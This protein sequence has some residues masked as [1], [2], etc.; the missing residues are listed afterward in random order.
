MSGVAELLTDAVGAEHVLAGESASEDY[1]HD[2]SLSGHSQ[3]PAFVV[4]PGSAEEVAEILRVATA[5]G[6]PVT[7]RGMGTGLSGAAVPQPGGILV[8][9]ERMNEIL[10]IDAENH[11]AVVQPGVTLRE[12]E[13]RTAALGLVY[14]VYPGEMSA[15]IGG[16]IATNAGGMRAVRYGVTREN[17]LGLQAVLATGEIVRSGGAVVK[18]SS[19]YDLTQLII[20]SE[21]T[22]AL[23]TEATLKLQPRPAVRA[24]LLAPFS[25]LEA[26]T[27]AVP[28]IIA[29]GLEPTLLEY[30]DALTMTAITYT[31]EMELG[32]PDAVRDAA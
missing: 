12:L 19:G 9:F 15:S 11:V 10:S 25:D 31:S 28:K 7:A 26:V 3:V 18:T 8:S 4:R 30:V 29:S 20:G 23:V 2:E 22:L 16:N 6:V 5:E 24:T 17:V 14:P 21:G 27:A 13:E 1:T 32:I